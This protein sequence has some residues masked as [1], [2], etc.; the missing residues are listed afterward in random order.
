[1]FSAST[2][3]NVCASPTCISSN[4]KRGIKR[5]PIPD[6]FFRN[7]FFFQNN[8]SV[9]FAT[10]TNKKKTIVGLT[11]RLKVLLRVSVLFFLFYVNANASMSVF[12]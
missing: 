3:F 1:M 7:Q 2:S 5:L 10:E 4:G 8:C 9:L 11:W 12:V 6:S